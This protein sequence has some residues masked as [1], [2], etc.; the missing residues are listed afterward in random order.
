MNGILQCLNFCDCMILLSI[1]SSRFIHVVT[2]SGFL[3]F[4]K[5]ELYSTV[6]IDHILFIQ[7]FAEGHVFFPSLAIENNAVLNVAV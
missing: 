4:V 2:V 7:S 6:C 3:I 1:M 5:S